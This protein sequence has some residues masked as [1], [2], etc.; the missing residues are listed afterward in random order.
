MAD[1]ENTVVI[2]GTSKVEASQITDKETMANATPEASTITRP[3]T[4][5]VRSPPP[6]GKKTFDT[7]PTEL[8]QS[9]ISN[10]W[11]PTDLRNVCLVDK[12][13]HEVAVQFLYKSVALDLGSA[14]DTK[15]ASFL[16]S[17]N[18]G[19][20]WMRVLRL[21]LANVEDTCNQEVQATF[22][23]RMI[24]E[25]LPRDILEE[26][27]WCPW[28]NFSADNLILLYK[29]QRKMTW[30]EV[31]QLDRPFATEL[32][33]DFIKQHN[34]FHHARRLAVYP[35]TRETL[36]HSRIFIEN[37]AEKLEELILHPHFDIGGSHSP[38]P[39]RI[40]PRELNDSA[41]GHG[42]LTGTLFANMLPFDKCKP[43][44]C[45]TRLRLHCINMRYCAS[46]WCKF[47]DFQKMEH[48]R[49]YQCPAAET[50]FG[51]LSRAQNLP[52]KLRVLEVQH[53]DNE[54]N[55]AL[56]ALDG[57]LCLV[58]G[59][60]DLLIDMQCVKALPGA[61]G[62]ARHGKTLELLSVH[63]SNDPLG[64]ISR[65]S[66]SE[67]AELVYD[68][69]SLDKICKAAKSLKQLSCA[70]P[71]RSIFKAPTSDWTAFETAVSTLHDVVTLHISSWPTNK[72][73]INLPRIQY[74]TLLQGYATQLFHSF[75]SHTIDTALTG[76]PATGAVSTNIGLPRSRLRLIAFGISDSVYE[77]TDSQNQKIYLRSSCIDAEGLK[78]IHA[79]PIG[80]CLRQFVEPR[81]EVLETTLSRHVA[82]PLRD[83]EHS[84]RWGDDDDA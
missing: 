55:E 65:T 50:L 61:A 41:T 30:L 77:R 38:S 24:L 82:M 43:F 35:E 14:N 75:A 63:G 64:S 26:F 39:T 6:V 69:E 8:K 49:V 10:L 20:R 3:T 67:H 45:L 19:L 37:T 22:A 5:R 83:G 66:P 29:T 72:S 4:S 60:E 36:E 32:K 21:Y 15:L 23:T 13:L 68:T 53:Q 47:V 84:S 56:L 81:S 28:K 44:E 11:R 78:R 25:M 70:W 1:E 73:P 76:P 16:S 57:L 48:L 31:M 74:E 52:R 33:A 46:T 59:I 40:A 42:L 12:E 54:E 9:I 79:T 2:T 34:L 27:S 71:E 62:I 51:E 80:W 18:I 7:L 17:R 58:S